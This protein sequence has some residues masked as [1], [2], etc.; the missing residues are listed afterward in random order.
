M[1]LYVGMFNAFCI[2]HILHALHPQH[3]ML[4]K[5]S[6]NGTLRQQHLSLAHR[7][8]IMAELIQGPLKSQPWA[9]LLSPLTTLYLFLK[10]ITISG[11]LTE[12]L[13][14]KTVKQVQVHEPKIQ[15]PSI[16]KKGYLSGQITQLSLII[17]IK[18][19]LHQMFFFQF[20]LEC[21]S[22]LQI[23]ICYM[24][25]E[26]ALNFIHSF[27]REQLYEHITHHHPLF[28]IAGG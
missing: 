18:G 3:L 20:D 12:Q 19:N 13:L 26:M 4:S 11:P 15:T 25:S 9:E 1:L 8:A 16:S 28:Q 22:C 21:E 5:S 23:K 7:T 24:K 2:L 10:S 17:A 6:L 27:D 14:L